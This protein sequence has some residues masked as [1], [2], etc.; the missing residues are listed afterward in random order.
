MEGFKK[1]CKP[2]LLARLKGEGSGGGPG[3]FK[4]E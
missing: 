2:G 4:F 1:T 3:G